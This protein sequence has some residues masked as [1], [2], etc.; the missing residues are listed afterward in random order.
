MIKFESHGISFDLNLNMTKNVVS[1]SPPLNLTKD[2]SSSAF[3]CHRKT[4]S[5][6]GRR[7]KYKSEADAAKAELGE[8]LQKKSFP[9]ALFPD[10]CLLLK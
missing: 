7:S 10:C 6:Y 9:S 1:E 2:H 5:K 8:S 3:C 4:R